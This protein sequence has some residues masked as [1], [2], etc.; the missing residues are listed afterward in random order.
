MT[1]VYIGLTADIL[2]P[3]IFNL[4]EKAR[5]Y[6]PIT[7]GLL[8][9][10][11]IKGNKHL[12][13]FT[14]EQRKSMVLGI[15]GVNSVVPQDDWNYKFNILKLRPKYFVH[16]DDWL[17]NNDSIIRSDVIQAL[18]SYGGN[19]VEIEYTKG[20]SA[21]ALTMQAREHASIPEIRVSLFRRVLTAPRIS[22]IIE[23]HSPI[24]AMVVESARISSNSE[25]RTFDGFWSSSLADSAVLGLP[26]NELVSFSTRLEYLRQILN[27]S[28][29][30]LLFDG[31][32]G[33]QIEH[34]TYNVL[35]LVKVGVGGVII[36][37]KKGLKQNSLIHD[38]SLHELEDP[39]SFAEKIASG[40]M[41]VKDKNFSIIARLESLI[42]GRDINEAMERATLY[43]AAGAD[44]IMIHSKQS[45]PN[46]IL[47]F[48]EKFRHMHPQTPLVAVPTTYNSIYESDLEEAGF[49]LVI[50]AN[51]MLRSSIYSMKNTSQEILKNMRSYESE[52]M[53]LPISEIL[54][55][56]EI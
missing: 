6:G 43:V 33:G 2:H 18:E 53:I 31:D 17:N 40:R 45:S 35:Q 16:G 8:T 38:D 42:S 48:A 14:W 51:H 39:E 5:E 27:V 19:L 46:Q 44:G 28:S 12:P 23:V 3:G 25:I 29:L 30:P 15:A 37:D 9:D 55:V 32:T 21:S 41:A 56:N 26:D 4:I 49:N 24:S 10:S 36:E 22:R 54:N 11:A 34:F 50:Y 7:V 20:V 1:N 47:D 52:A 13:S